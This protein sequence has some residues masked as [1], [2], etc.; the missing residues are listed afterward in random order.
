MRQQGWHMARQSAH[1]SSASPAHV[2]NEHT[3]G[4]GAATG[5]AAGLVG[6]G[7]HQRRQKEDAEHATP[8]AVRGRLDQRGGEQRIRHR[9]EAVDRMR[10]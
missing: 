4:N 6:G 10:A 8:Q 1:R 7:S 5:G 3:E 9:E 2:C